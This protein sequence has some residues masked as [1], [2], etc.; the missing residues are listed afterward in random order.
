MGDDPVVDAEQ[1]DP[2]VAEAVDREALHPYPAETL[3]GILQTGSPGRARPGD[4]DP[5]G[6][7]A[8]VLQDDPLS[9]V[10]LPAQR[11]A[12]PAQHDRAAVAGIGGA[13]PSR[14]SVPARLHEHGVARLGALDRVLDR[15]TRAHPDHTMVIGER[16]PSR[17]D[18]QTDEQ[19]NSNRAHGEPPVRADPTVAATWAQGS[20]RRTP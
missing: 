3:P 13:G 12:V 19:E 10:G 5:L 4:G 14:F 7:V 1:E 11:D 20:Y 16:G 15:L 17:R 9:V 6:L 2:V 8:R 18:T